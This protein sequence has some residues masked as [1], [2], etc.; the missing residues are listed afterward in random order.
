MTPMDQ[1]IIPANSNPNEQAL[2][3]FSV[4]SQSMWIEWDWMGLNPKQLKL[5]LN[6]FPIPSNPCVLGIMEQALKRG[7][8]VPVGNRHTIFLTGT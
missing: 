4:S 6:F 3:A 7:I 8:S 5:L 2:S 1:A